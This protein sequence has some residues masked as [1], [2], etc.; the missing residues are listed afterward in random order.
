VEPARFGPIDRRS[1]GHRGD[2]LLLPFPIKIRGMMHCRQ[3][4]RP[5]TVAD[6]QLDGTRV[7]NAGLAHLQNLSDSGCLSLP[8]TFATDDGVK[9]LQQKLPKTRILWDK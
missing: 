4:G 3:W 7:R 9:P 1:G 8:G 5:Q 2:F 6:A